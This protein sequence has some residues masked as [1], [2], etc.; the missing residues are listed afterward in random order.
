MAAK[1]WNLLKSIAQYPFLVLYIFIYFRLVFFEIS[2][3]FNGKKTPPYL[4]ITI[5]LLKKQTNEQNKKKQYCTDNINT[6]DY[7]YLFN[8]HR[9]AM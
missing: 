1:V 4:S 8:D 2:N 9:G 3:F 7:I 5:L 6:Y